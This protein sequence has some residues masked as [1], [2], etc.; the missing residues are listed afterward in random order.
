MLSTE[1]LSLRECLEFRI[2][3]LN[4]PID[5]QMLFEDTNPVEIE[6]GCGKGRFLITSATTYPDV[7]YIGIERS[8]H[9]FHIMQERSVKQGLTNV[10]LLRDEAG[11]FVQKHIP[12]V[13]ITAYHVYFPDPW[14]KKRHR[15]RRLFKT[16]FVEQVGRTLLDGGTIDIAT[17]YE[18]YFDEIIGLL[19]ASPV[20]NQI[21]EL[22]ERVQNLG[23]GMTNFEVKYVNQGRKIYRAGFRKDEGTIVSGGH[24]GE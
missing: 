4:E 2:R 17:D 5:W 21:D 3:D 19:D 13:S 24:N 23:T 16:E 18:E 6:I 9:Y 12:D 10:R 14:P 15:K 22:P 11:N 1:T 8:L 20:L 7:N